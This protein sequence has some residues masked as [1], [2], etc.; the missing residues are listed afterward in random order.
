PPKPIDAARPV[1]KDRPPLAS[2]PRLRP[3]IIASTRFS[4]SMRLETPFRHWPRAA[5]RARRRDRQL[6]GR[7]RSGALWQ[8][9]ARSGLRA[10]L[11]AK[12]RMLV[13]LARPQAA[14]M[15]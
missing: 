3:V 1:E 10:K 7:R 2:C 11:K 15:I 6:A 9:H 5:D 14:R 8:H 4:R 12:W 13:R